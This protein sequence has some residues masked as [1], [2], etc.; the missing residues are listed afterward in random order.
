MGVTDGS[1]LSL[2]ELAIEDIGRDHIRQMLKSLADL[3]AREATRPPS[4]RTRGLR[5]LLT[6]LARCM[7]LF[8]RRL[9]LSDQ[10]ATRRSAPGATAA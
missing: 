2:A 6:R 10:S 1:G 7:A 8:S 9:T 5:A 3:H 4:R